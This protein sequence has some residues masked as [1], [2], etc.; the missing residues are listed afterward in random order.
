MGVNA[1]TPIRQN[2][3]PMWAIRDVGLSVSVFFRHGSNKIKPLETIATDLERS[4]RKEILQS[5][6]PTVYSNICF[7]K[8]RH[9]RLKIAESNASQGKYLDAI[10]QCELL[11]A[12]APD[13]GRQNALP[14][15]FKAYYEGKIEEQKGNAALNEESSLPVVLDRVAKDSDAHGHFRKA[16]ESMRQSYEF[17]LEAEEF[18]KVFEVGE[19]AAELYSKGGDSKTPLEIY[20]GLAVLA[21][22]K[23]RY[24]SAARFYLAAS[25]LTPDPEKAQLY[26]KLAE[27]CLDMHAKNIQARSLAEIH[28][29][30]GVPMG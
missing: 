17:F 21:K 4:G 13:F 6:G 9:E 26:K 5:G 29:S 30:Q 3:R 16:A 22:E 14:L 12:I 2:P 20:E 15:A 25:K 23:R 7:S 24:D 10:Y 28:F 27:E 11:C 19:E 1:T 8:V 18:G